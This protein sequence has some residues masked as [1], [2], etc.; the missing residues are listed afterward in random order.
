MWRVAV[1]MHSAHEYSKEKKIESVG[2][3]RRRRKTAHKT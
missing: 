1:Q 3:N 2:E